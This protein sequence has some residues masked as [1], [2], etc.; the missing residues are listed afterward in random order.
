[1]GQVGISE[2]YI[3]N[4]SE[5]KSY[6]GFNVL[7]RQGGIWSGLPADLAFNLSSFVK[8]GSQSYA[9][10]KFHDFSMTFP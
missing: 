6:C 5:R 2:K 10:V 1:L 8:Q 7:S 4:G 3:K 9:S